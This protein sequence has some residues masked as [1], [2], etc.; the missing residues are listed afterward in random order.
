VN[1]RWIRLAA[2]AF[3][4]TMVAG[5]CASEDDEGADG[6]ARQGSSELAACQVTDTGGI[7][8][9]SFNQTAYAGVERAEEELGVEARFLESTAEADY[10]PNLSAFVDQGCDLI[11]PVGFFLADATQASAEENPDQKYA[12]VDY[13]YEEPIDNVKGLTFETD[14]AAFLA[15]YL[16]AGSTQ[17]GKVGTFGGDVLP[18][19]T[20][21]MDGFLAGVQQYNADNGTDVEVL[22]WDGTDGQFTGDFEDQDKG[23][24]VT[25]SLIDEG[26]DIIMPV[27]GPVGLG[28]VAAAQ[29]EE[30]V[31]LIWV[32][33]DGCLSVADAC[34]LFLTSV[35][36]KM[37][38]AVFDTIQSVVDDDF[39][40]EVYSGTLENDGVGIPELGEDV[41]AEL[42]DKIEEYRQ[43]IIDGS[44][45]VSPS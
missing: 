20:I 9:A 21:F 26:A 10:E 1:S 16:A 37:D 33:T 25:K 34:D 13:A 23:K 28:S 4:A 15:G 7:D 44:Q 14:Q 40:N 8:D 22:G 43:A 41:P 27:A 35:Q 31:K 5:A 11:V 32:D 17:T 29:E 36:K 42:A 19:V 45:S 12:I 24:Q 18:T 6:S 2:L 38:N 39:D 3:A 30:G